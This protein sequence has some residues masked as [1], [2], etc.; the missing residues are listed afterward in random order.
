MNR[1]SAFA[2]IELIIAIV[3]IAILIGLCLPTIERTRDEAK[4]TQCAMNMRTIGQAIIAYSKDNQGYLPLHANSVSPWVI[5]P[6]GLYDL[7]D[8]TWFFQKG[9]AFTN[10][11]PEAYANLGQLINAGYLGNW[12]L[13]SPVAVKNAGDPTFAPFRLC[14]GE[15]PDSITRL[16]AHFH[17]TYFLNPHWSYS[18][19]GEGT[20]TLPTYRVTW[21][22]KLCDYPAQLALACEMIYGRGVNTPVPHPAGG[23]SCYWNLLFSD[24][25]VA[26]VLDGNVAQM[27]AS[28][29]FEINT[30]RKFDD[31]LDILETEA[32][33][34]D[35]QKVMALP[36]YAAKSMNVSP[37]NYG[38]LIFREYAYPNTAKYGTISYLGPVNWQ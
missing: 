7:R 21:F 19:Y 38:P 24:G 31:S 14:P 13:S 37:G 18:S 16:A 4:L 26:R 6:V 30:V 3:V 1:Y 23:N 17:S 28:G 36:G 12:D 5:D 32:E 35:I 8:F 25:H 27:G 33:G 11:P 22:R 34:G 29:G 10:D 9:A 15:D 20:G 2:F